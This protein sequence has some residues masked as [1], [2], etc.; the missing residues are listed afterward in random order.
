[1]RKHSTMKE[2]ETFHAGSI[3]SSNATITDQPKFFVTFPYPYMNGKLHLGHG[4]TIMNAELSARYMKS[5]GYNVLFP[6]GFHGSGMPIVTCAKKLERE[7]AGKSEPSEG[8]SQIKILKDMGVADDDIEKFKNPEFWIIYFSEKAKDDL[9]EFH[10]NA[11]FTRSFYTTQ[12]N[13]YY[14]SFIQW[15]FN[16]LIESGYVYKGKRNVIFSLRDNQPCADHDRSGDGEG[17]VPVNTFVKLIETPLGR[18]MATVC[19]INGKKIIQTCKTVNIFRIGSDPIHYIANEWAFINI[20]HQYENVVLIDKIENSSICENSSD[21]II[22]F[23]TGFYLVENDDVIS[24]NNDVTEFDFKFSEPEKTVKSRSGDVCIV[25]KTDQWF[26]N[27]GD[28]DVKAKISE[29]VTNVFKTV[30]KSVHTMFSTAV[31]WLNEWA[32][33]RN[34]GLGTYIPGTTDL[35]DSLSDSTIYMAYYTISHLVTKLPLS[36]VN[37]KM[38]NYIFFDKNDEP[39]ESDHIKIIDEMKNEF[40]YWY[41]VDL[42][43]SGKDLVPNHLTMSLYNHYFI[44]K[45]EKYLPRQYNVNGYLML[46]CNKMSKSTGNFMTLRDAIDKFGVNATRFALANSDGVEDGNFDSSL[47]ETISAKLMKEYEWIIENIHNHEKL[48]ELEGFNDIWD[49]I[50]ISE[51]EKC[52]KDADESYS[53]SKYSLVNRAFYALQSARDDHRKNTYYCTKT[54]SI[55]WSLFKKYCQACITILYPICPTYTCEIQNLF[56]TIGESIDSNWT[57]NFEKSAKYYYYRDIINGVASECNKT[58]DKMN[59][60][61][62]CDFKFVINIFNRFSDEETLII[63]NIKNNTI[64]EYMATIDKKKYGAY[65][66]FIAYVKKNIEKYSISWMEFISDGEEYSIINEYIPKIIKAHKFEIIYNETNESCK[67][68]YGPGSP[69]CAVDVFK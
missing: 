32:C 17:V 10:I 54:C 29:Y 7:L 28:P 30:D 45:N 61:K 56:S 2:I 1:M 58:I 31:N 19:D 65:K 51:I 35:I 68:K 18:I 6:F 22:T 44:W 21:E 46:N 16:H 24:K 27:Y 49:N 13:P 50:F 55:K 40:K 52:I 53:H 9:I 20:M 36:E 42:R 15:Q 43:V 66:G 63:H 26:I 47:A 41:P 34:Y 48:I 5:K 60:K 8:A 12:M 23:G 11:D 38:W 4:Y 59:K 39:F 57:I 25:A 67:F 64:D 37:Y 69:M 3:K 14:D 33:S 62:V